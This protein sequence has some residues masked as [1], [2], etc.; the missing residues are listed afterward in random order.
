[1][2][3]KNINITNLYSKIVIAVFSILLLILGLFKNNNIDASFL[4]DFPSSY[5]FFPWAMNIRYFV[6]KDN[7]FSNLMYT[8]DHQWLNYIG[9]SSIDDAQN[10]IPLS[11]E[12]LET[13]HIKLKTIKQTLNDQG[14]K[15]YLVI[16]SNKNTIYPED[17]QRIA[18]K[19][20]SISRLDQ[21][22]DYESANEGLEI[23]E[24]RS[25]LIEATKSRPTYY[26]TDS[27]WNHFGSWL[28][29]S[30]IMSIISRDFPQIRVNPIEEF[31]IK[32]EPIS[33]DLAVLSGDILVEETT[34]TFALKNPRDVQLENTFLL[35]L[36]VN[37]SYI[38]D[39]DLP[40]ALVFRDSNYINLYPYMSQHFRKS[41][42][43]WSFDFRYDLVDEVKPDL[44][45]YEMTERY[46]HRLLDLP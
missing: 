32:N 33:G 26:A 23:I 28:G 37:T 1:M 21:L 46:V 6:L 27:H 29:Y 25:E 39:P 13:I 45:I 35:N 22:I 34:E 7:F 15:F 38:D 4:E 3:I 19:I 16:P 11:D 9:E 10:A 8:N 42:T 41:V 36:N 12:Q 31:L 2:M 18:P 14:I 44:V 43:V 30:K 40:V 5:K 17:L 24:F 20:Q